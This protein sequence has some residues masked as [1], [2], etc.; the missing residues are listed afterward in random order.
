MI[1]GSEKIFLFAM[2]AMKKGM[3]KEGLQAL[4]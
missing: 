1:V 3:M 4:L 2:K